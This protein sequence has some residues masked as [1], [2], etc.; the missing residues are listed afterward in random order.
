MS[1]NSS[2][3]EQ[4]AHT[5]IGYGNNVLNRFGAGFVEKV[6]ENALA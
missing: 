4:A 6:C 2:F 1:A 5:A 3:L